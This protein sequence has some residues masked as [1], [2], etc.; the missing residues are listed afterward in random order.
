MQIDVFTLFPD[1]FGWFQSQRHVANALARGHELR[2]ASYRDYS[3]LSASQVDDTPFGGGA[4]MVLFAGLVRLALHQRIA[5]T[6]SGFRAY[7]RPVMEVCQREFPA[8]FPDA[9][10]LIANDP[11]AGVSF[12]DRAR[13]SIPQRPGI[14]VVRR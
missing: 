1:W 11:F 9:P 6:T 5:D 2:Y 13:I 10:L 4:G 12:D 7:A 3:T 14:G 8:D